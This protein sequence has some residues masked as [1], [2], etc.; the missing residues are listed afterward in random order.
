MTDARSFL[1]SLNDCELSFVYIY[2]Y[3]T[4]MKECGRQ[5]LDDEVL[6]RGLSNDH[7]RG[8]VQKTEF[9]LTNTGCVRCDSA[10]PLISDICQVCHHRYRPNR[11]IPGDKP[12]EVDDSAWYIKLAGI[13]LEGILE[14]LG[15]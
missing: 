9:Q 14:G 1:D 12:P 15:S 2:R 3:N 11:I 7:M 10:K 6:R 4:Y 5:L 8:N 13:V